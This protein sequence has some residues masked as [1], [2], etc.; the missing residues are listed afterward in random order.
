MAFSA[1][2]PNIRAQIATNAQNSSLASIQATELREPV[3]AKQLP[4]ITETLGDL[5]P[6]RQ[7]HWPLTPDLNRYAENT[8]AP[9]PSVDSNGLTVNPYIRRADEIGPAHGIPGIGHVGTILTPPGWK[10]GD[11]PITDTEA[12]D[13]YDDARAQA[14]KELDAVVRSR[15]TLTAAEHLQRSAQESGQWQ[16][17]LSIDNFCLGERKWIFHKWQERQASRHSQVQQYH[18]IHT[19][20][21]VNVVPTPVHPPTQTSIYAYQQHQQSQVLRSPLVSHFSSPLSAGSV[22]NRL[23]CL[24]R[25]MTLTSS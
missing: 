10:I 6:S 24:Q 11:V 7:S 12:D 4:N 8:P 1:R 19:Q 15:E 2:L 20:A 23:Q 3:P 5:A 16:R 25:G 18:P 21:Q 22:N 13:L 14:V 17:Q 9:T